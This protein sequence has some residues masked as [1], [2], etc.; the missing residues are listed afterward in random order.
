V[1]DGVTCDSCAALVLTAPYGGKCDTYCRSFGQVCVAAAEEVDDNCEVKYTAPCGAEVQGTSDMLC[2]CQTPASADFALSGRG[3]PGPS[4]IWLPQAKGAGVQACFEVVREAS[5]CAQD[6]FTYVARGDANCGCRGTDGT[7][8]IRNDLNADYYQIGASRD[9]SAGSL[10]VMSYNTEY[11][12]YWDGRVGDYGQKIRDVGPSV[13]GI[14]ECQD[15][16]ALESASGYTAV[17]TVGN[18]NPILY[19]PEKVSYIDGSAGYMSIPRDDHAQRYVSFAKFRFGSTE[20]WHFNTHLPHRHNEASSRNTHAR[21]A[22]SLLRKREELRAADMPTVV[23]GDMNPFASDGAT[24]GSFEDNLI[25]AG[26]SKAYQ[27]R[28]NP[29]YSGLD[30]IFAS[31]HWDASNG[32]DLG[33][34]RSDHPAIAVDL[35]L[36]S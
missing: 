9:P 24:M 12:G 3:V 2:K 25:T 33:T 29:G 14:Q 4:E 11:R 22:Q 23:T 28:G 27:A 16:A 15:Y 17:P 20:F 13:V 21:I 1:D 35:A 19:N 6:Y 36:K 18:K 8:S 10:K 26:F 31:S 7:L 5:R 30:N 32:A 34:G